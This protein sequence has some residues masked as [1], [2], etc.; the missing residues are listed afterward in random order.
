M[1][2]QVI[3][4]QCEIE[5]NISENALNEVTKDRLTRLTFETVDFLPLEIF[6][7]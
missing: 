1:C 6:R 5:L 4:M 7:H 3:T 2:K